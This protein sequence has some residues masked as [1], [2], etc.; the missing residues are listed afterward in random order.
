M[1]KIAHS[2]TSSTFLYRNQNLS[3]CSVHEKIRRQRRQIVRNLQTTLKPGRQ[4]RSIS[5]AAKETM[6][7]L[8]C[9]FSLQQILINQF[10]T[11][12]ASGTNLSAA[13]TFHSL[14][15]TADNNS[16]DDGFYARIKPFYEP[17]T[18]AFLSNVKTLDDSI[19]AG[20]TPANFNE[21]IKLLTASLLAV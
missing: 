12:V 11:L 5:L 10:T 21:Y 8:D 16:F 4:A 20:A 18:S 13:Q 3:R 19:V 15:L 7:K 1:V 17:V 2:P 6:S 9:H 14:A